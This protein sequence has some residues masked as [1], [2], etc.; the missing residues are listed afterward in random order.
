MQIYGLQPRVPQSESLQ[1]KRE[2]ARSEMGMS[3]KKVSPVIFM[4]YVEV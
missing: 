1:L 4:V 2:R 3:K